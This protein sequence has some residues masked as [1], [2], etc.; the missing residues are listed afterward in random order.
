MARITVEDCIEA[1]PSRFELVLVA[2]ERA[3]ELNA[4]ARSTVDVENEKTTVVSLR[5]IAAR[6]LDLDNLRE[7][8]VRNQQRIAPPE[9]PPGGRRP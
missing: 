5:E 3:R 1:V 6:N 7:K 4:G 9:E 2:A 8:L